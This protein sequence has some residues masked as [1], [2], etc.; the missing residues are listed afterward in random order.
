[1][2]TSNKVRSMAFY[3]N[4]AMQAYSSALNGLTW[5]ERNLCF[6]AVYFLDLYLIEVAFG[7]FQQCS[8][9]ELILPWMPF[10]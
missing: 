6:F 5:K 4:L 10:F 2:K 3:N 8:F 9:N 7:C 1:M